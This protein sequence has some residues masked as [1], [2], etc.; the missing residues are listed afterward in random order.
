MAQFKKNM[1]GGCVQLI[2]LNK[3]CNPL[4]QLANYASQCYPAFTF[5][6]T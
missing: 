2:Y 4:I 6:I 1:F 3:R 5:S